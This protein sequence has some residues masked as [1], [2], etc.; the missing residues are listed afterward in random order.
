[1]DA[2]MSLHQTHAMLG[3]MALLDEKGA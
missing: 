1:L 2:V 3:A